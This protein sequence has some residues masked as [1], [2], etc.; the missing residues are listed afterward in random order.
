MKIRLSQK[1]VDVLMFLGKYKMMLAS[2][3]KMIYQG[4]DYHRKRLKVLEK[5]RYIR[6][7]KRIY[8]KLDDKG[9]KLVRE[10][11]YDY[12][13]NCRKPE[14]ME[15]LKEI[16]RIASLTINSDIAFTA[17][18]DL[19]DNNIYTETSRKYLGELK[20]LNEQRIVY[21]ISKNKQL[22]Y[23]SKVKNDIQKLIDYSNII[24]FIDNKKIIEN[25]NEFIFGKDSLLFIETSKECFCLLRVLNKI[26]SHEIVSSIFS[27]KEILLSNWKLADYMT[28]DE[29]YII[30]MPFVDIEKIY[31]LCLY[32]DNNSSLINKTYIITLKENQD[33]IKKSISDK[34]N[35]VILDTWLGGT[36]DKEIET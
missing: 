28:I 15:R 27:N 8:I 7:V 32:F 12:N 31:A 14:Y 5:N 30:F 21:Y 4:N 13:F 18:W 1:D 17:S 35:I 16:A 22:S 19:K 23:I 25:A 36:N 2:D 33:Y 3:C 29:K 26:D 11:G 10:F 20:I 34:I 9:T 24:V 6:R